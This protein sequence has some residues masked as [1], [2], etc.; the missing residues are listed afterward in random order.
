M[1]NMTHVLL[2]EQVV[3]W[4]HADSLIIGM[5]KEAELARRALENLLEDDSKRDAEKTTIFTPVHVEKVLIVKGAEN[6][7]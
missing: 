1:K 6:V 4:L 7:L 2:T 5:P 3:D